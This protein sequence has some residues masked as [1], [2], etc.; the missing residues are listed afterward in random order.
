MTAIGLSF[1]EKV[2]VSRTTFGKPSLFLTSVR[3]WRLL[4]AVA[5]AGSSP[6]GGPPGKLLHD[7]GQEGHGLK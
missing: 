2:Q 1:T 6:A 7:P 3:G 5:G 4:G